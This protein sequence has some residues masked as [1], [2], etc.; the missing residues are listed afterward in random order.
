MGMNNVYCTAP[1]NG[2]T[3]RED[4][5]VRTCCVGTV[6][7]GNLNQDSIFDIEHSPKLIEIQNLMLLGKPATLNCKDCINSD[8]QGG[9]TLRQYYNRTYTNIDNLK[10]KFIDIRWNNVC[11]LA[12]QYCNSKFSSTWANKLN[13]VNA[14]PI[15]QYQDELLEWILDRADQVT[16]I[17]LVGGEPMLMKQNYALLE[18]L[19]IDCRISIITNLSYNLLTLPCWS[20]LLNRPAE[21][22]AWNV[23]LENTGNK[24][25]YVRNGASW[26][27]IKVNFK[28]LVQHWPNNVSL[29]IVYSLFSAFDLVD[30]ID[31]YHSLGIKKFNLF[32]I[33]QNNAMNVFNMPKV[34]QTLA[35]EQLE[36]IQT[37]HWANLHPDDR[38]FYPLH[39][40]DVLIN[41]LGC[42]DGD[43][44]V[45]NFNKQIDFYNKWRD[46]PFES[47]WPNLVNL[48]KTYCKP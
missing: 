26:D 6:E 21:N 43:T 23:S 1:W 39:G 20:N 24:F 36:K 29:N 15:K 45:T 10:L 41:N 12:C 46:A 30:D 31:H 14:R 37:A 13:K 40:I 4:G 48:V 18:K 5:I 7:L 25:E 33:Q 42:T 3:I 8:Q 17:M 16:E 9:H 27:Q 47:L 28:L 38:D 44:T 35:K 2:L 34:V 11:N 22:I 19:P 32:N